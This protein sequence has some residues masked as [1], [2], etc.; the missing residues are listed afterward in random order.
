MPQ[1]SELTS[2]SSLIGVETF[3]LVQGAITKKTAIA[4]IV[5]Q[6]IDVGWYGA[7]GDGSTD[8]TTAINNALLAIATTGK[9]IVTTPNNR[10][11]KVTGLI[12]VPTGASFQMGD[13][14]ELVYYGSG[15][16]VRI[17]PDAPDTA[18]ETYASGQTQRRDRVYVRKASITWPT[19]AGA[20]DTTSKG[21]QVVNARYSYFEL[22]AQGFYTGI[23]VLGVGT[24]PVT[25]QTYSAGGANVGN[26][27]TVYCRN[28]FTH[29]LTTRD[30]AGGYANQNTV[31]GKLFRND[32]SMTKTGSRGFDGSDG[33]N[34]WTFINVNSEGSTIEQIYRFAGP[35]NTIVGG[36][37]E[38]ATAGMVKVLNNG[39]VD[40][41]GGYIGSVGEELVSCDSGGNYT[42]HM[43]NG[44]WFAN[45][46]AANACTTN[47][48]SGS[49]GYFTQNR[50]ND[51]KILFEDTETA[52]HKYYTLA[53]KLDAAN[54]T[55]LTNPTLNID[56]GARA[57]RFR[58][59]S[60]DA[61]A[62]GTVAAWSW[63]TANSFSVFRQ[64]WHWENND[65]NRPLRLGS[66]LRLWSDTNGIPRF[67]NGA[68]SSTT[69]GLSVAT[70][71]GSATYDPANLVDGAGVTTTVTVTGAVLGDFVTAVSFSLDIQGILLTAWVS[72]A[73]TV[74]VRFQNETGGAIDL[75]SGTIRV[76]V[77]KM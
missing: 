14:A 41:V 26:I 51:R 17:E 6:Y 9:G 2:T 74:S 12:T 18:A 24:D 76:R 20:T 44:S 46:I 53:G 7:V 1:I 57:M 71:S 70:L 62:D 21:I 4:N 48:L 43:Q 55:G 13:G 8:D 40:I 3:P 32:S 37:F 52:A 68:P 33:A 72:A 66:T 11:F 67:K 50:L 35:Y 25:G 69:D 65:Y 29:I 61:S 23:E 16:C 36:R 39:G 45:G 19:S 56:A 31:L 63:A 60:D 15:T 27:F 34:G 75:G 5:P 38:N 73:D 30:G 47:R 54:P 77:A 10:D 28:N 49:T 59:A 64:T 42:I 22:G 58:A